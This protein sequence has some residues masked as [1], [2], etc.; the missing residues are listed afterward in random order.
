MK[1]YTKSRARLNHCIPSPGSLCLISMLVKARSCPTVVSVRPDNLI[2]N[3]RKTQAYKQAMYAIGELGRK[4]LPR[5][6]PAEE[7]QVTLG[8]SD[9]FCSWTASNSNPT[10]ITA[11]WPY[12]FS[13]PL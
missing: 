11:R 5:A 3:P 9:A 12:L 10:E 8:A 7:L 13:H 4:G 1:A 6:I 2:L